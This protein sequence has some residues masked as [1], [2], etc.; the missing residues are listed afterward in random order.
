MSEVPVFLERS[1]ISENGFQATRRN[2]L[3]P[4]YRHSQCFILVPD[5]LQYASAKS[6]TAPGLQPGDT[7]QYVQR[8][9]KL[10]FCDDNS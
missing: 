4:Y 10:R 2:G 1:G 8:Q 6:T 5:W 9:L 3:L 7:P